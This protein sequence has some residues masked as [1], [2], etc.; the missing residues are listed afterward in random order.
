METKQILQQGV[1]AAKAGQ[2]RE[3]R[4]LFKRAIQLD[5]TN[6]Q[7]W[8]WLSAVLDDPSQQRMCLERVL[9]INPA[10]A[11]AQK[12]VAWFKEQSS[13]QQQRPT[14][15]S[16][17]SSSASQSPS[18]S[19]SATSSAPARP[20][21]R[22]ASLPSPSHVPAQE[23]GL[24]AR[25]KKKQTASSATSPA[26]TTQKHGLET[27][28]ATEPPP[29]PKTEPA[30][31]TTPAPAP[32]KKRRSASKEA[33]EAQDNLKYHCPWC[34][35]RTSLEQKRCPACKTKLVRRVRETSRRSVALSFLGGAW[36]I[37][38][39]FAALVNL[40]LFGDDPSHMFALFMGMLSFGL[41]VALLYRQIWA[42]PTVIIATIALL[43][44]PVHEYIWMVIL[45][46]LVWIPL[47][48]RDF[49][50]PK[51]RIVPIFAQPP[52]RR[53]FCRRSA[54]SGARNVVYGGARVAGG[55]AERP[56]KCPLPDDVRAGVCAAQ[57]V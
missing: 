21:R 45:P 16:A 34:G 42:Y 14:T 29:K 27:L 6:E 36:G 35:A 39:L 31:A 37:G 7:A 57:A 8:L 1:A 56:S 20:S 5:D 4:A 38:S 48:Y 22:A 53:P 18:Q 12:G 23:D 11:R 17:D 33:K 51:H 46:L 3:A 2:R 28:R 41:A 9:K 55:G 15:A 47:S 24:A 54:L 49:F 30:P 13:Q 32:A 40:K 10:N 26:A 52:P 19:P 50:G 43:L 25:L 44:H